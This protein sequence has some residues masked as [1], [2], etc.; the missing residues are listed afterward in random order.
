MAGHSEKTK[1]SV[2]LTSALGSS[3]APFMVSALIVALPT[4]GKEFSTDAVLLGWITSAFFL[5]A[6]VFLVPIG[7]LA[8][9]HGVKRVFSMGIAIYG[10]SALLCLLSPS[11]MFLI[12]ARFLTGIGAAMIF[13]TSIALLSLVFP[14]EERGKAI[15]FNVMAMT[16]GFLLG[17]L[18]GG[19]LIFYI[20]WRAIFLFVIPVTLI[21]TALI[22]FRIPGECALARARKP[23]RGGSILFGIM[24]FFFIIGCTL[25]PRVP[26]IVAIFLGVVFITLFIRWERNCNSP[27]LDLH[28]FSRNMVFLRANVVVLMAWAGSFAVSVLGS[29]YLQDVMGFDSRITGLILLSQVIATIVFVP[30]GGRLS[31]RI[32]P[33]LVASGGL[34]VLIAGLIPLVFLSRITPISVVIAAYFLYGLGIAFFQPSLAHMVINAVGQDN[35]GLA[36]SMAESM[37]LVGI[38]LS[39]AI[40]TVIFSLVLG[41]AAIVPAHISAFLSANRTTMLFFTAISVSGLIICFTLRHAGGTA[42]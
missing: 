31:D 39:L 15:G 34:I 36:G 20:G 38:T 1:R 40:T 32:S 12:A 19:F 42:I 24:I 28:L 30:Y 26:G 33:G 5:G 11:A 3:L 6:A 4:I 35:Y 21:V 41:G 7:G 23:D 18:A 8:D 25:L 27:L 10:V 37:R 2:L 13:G 29:L 17:F 9:I 16:L 22:R 14:P